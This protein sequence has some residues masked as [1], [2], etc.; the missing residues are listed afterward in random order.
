MNEGIIKQ[1]VIK[2]NGDYYFVSTVN[3]PMRS[4]LSVMA[5]WRN[6][7]WPPP[8]PNE[9]MVWA[10]NSGGGKS[11]DILH[12]QGY[13]KVES[14]GKEHRKLCRRIAK[15]GGKALNNREYQTDKLT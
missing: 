15:K 5:E 12:C 1:D 2:H 3:L 7:W 8:Y 11:G 13:R 14:A 10:S 9:T 4:L 6:D